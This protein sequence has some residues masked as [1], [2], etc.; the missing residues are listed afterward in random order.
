MLWKIFLALELFISLPKQPLFTFTTKEGAPNYQDLLHF[1]QL[2]M[3]PLWLNGLFLDPIFHN[4][5]IPFSKEVEILNFK[6][7]WSIQQAELYIYHLMQ[8]NAPLLAAMIRAVETFGI[9]ASHQIRLNLQPGVLNSQSPLFPSM[10][11]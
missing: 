11:I 5:L 1:Q 8:F 7:I 9:H 3:E 10:T 2:L 6:H 4:P